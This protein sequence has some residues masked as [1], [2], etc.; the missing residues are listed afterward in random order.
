MSLQAQEAALKD[1]YRWLKR[2]VKQL[3]THPLGP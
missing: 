2:K 1:L 3:L